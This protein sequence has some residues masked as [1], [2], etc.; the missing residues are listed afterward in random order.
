[1]TTKIEITSEKIMPQ[2][3]AIRFA[4]VGDHFDLDGGRENYIVKSKTFKANFEPI[5]NFPRDITIKLILERAEST[6]ELETSV[7]NSKLERP[8][9]IIGDICITPQGTFKLISQAFMIRTNGLYFPNW[10]FDAVNEAAD[11]LNPEHQDDPEADD[12][13]WVTLNES[14]K[15]SHP[16]NSYN[17]NIPN[18]P[19]TYMARS[20]KFISHKMDGSEWSIETIVE[21]AGHQDIQLNTNVEARLGILPYAKSGDIVLNAD[22]N[23]YKVEF[24][25]FS[26]SP[27]SHLYSFGLGLENV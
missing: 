18:N 10:H 23:L 4:D 22:N 14:I 15:L 13:I 26:R 27:S 16:G 3:D 7:I 17:F 24:K 12:P 20:K 6:Y 19:P 2:N 1:M 9:A 11:S 21:A 5:H 8:P 25:L